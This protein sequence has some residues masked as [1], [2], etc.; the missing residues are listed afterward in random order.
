MF[1]VE[2]EGVVVGGCYVGGRGAEEVAL[3]C[4]VLRGMV[5][6][7][8]QL[9]ALGLIVITCKGIDGYG[10]FL[11]E[12][13][14]LPLNCVKTFINECIFEADIISGKFLPKVVDNHHGFLLPFHFIASNQA[15][16]FRIELV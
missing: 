16:Q 12:P 5:G 11:L 10:S 8:G 7:R 13:L 1:L 4:A 2:E 14:V 3:H 15:K 6:F 9:K